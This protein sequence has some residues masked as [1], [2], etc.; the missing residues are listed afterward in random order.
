MSVT[1]GVSIRARARRAALTVLMAAAVAGMV[2]SGPARAQ[3]AVKSANLPEVGSR[4]AASRPAEPAQ[5]VPAQAVP[6]R[7]GPLNVHVF[8]DS[9]G[10]GMWAGLYRLLPAAEGYR[11]TKHSK[12][13]TGLV[14]RDYF[15]WPTKVREVTARERV[16]VAVVM[17]GT[18]DR[19]PI[20]ENGRHALRSPAWERIYTARIDAMIE[21]LKAAGA[22]IFWVELPAMRSPRFGGDMQYFNGLYRARAAAHGITF[23]PT[24]QRT[25]GEGG[26]YSAYGTDDA[27]R[28]RLMRTDDGIHFT[29]R[30]YIQLAGFVTQAMADPGAVSVPVA[31]PVPVPV[32]DSVPVPL[33]R[34]AAGDDN[35][36]RRSE[37]EGIVSTI[38]NAIEDLRGLVLPEP[39]PGR[40]DDLRL[41]RQ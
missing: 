7:A 8:G 16:D 27:G 25:L 30:G 22:E 20:V 13:S 17:I 9:L 33:P 34:P 21:P 24:W 28:T 36:P 26:A 41:D 14:R 32:P 3:E 5:A 1:A 10:D 6:A 31:E 37:R 11:V 38:A 35:Q 4:A 15:D 39:R 2:A 23:V 18:N 40:A 19:Q 29:M 12:V